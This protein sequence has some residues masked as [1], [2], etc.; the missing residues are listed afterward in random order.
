M[1]KIEHYYP[2]IVLGLPVAITTVLTHHLE[3]SGLFSLLVGLIMTFYSMFAY[4]KPNK[5]NDIS[6]FAASFF[7]S[8]GFVLVSTF[9]T[10]FPI[11][12]VV[13]LFY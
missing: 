10:A 8:F 6:S 2:Y 11:W 5:K 13:F 9:F 1:K 3:I 4:F 7:L 12:M